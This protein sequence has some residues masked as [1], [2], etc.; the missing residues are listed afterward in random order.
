MRYFCSINRNNHIFPTV[1]WC[2]GLFNAVKEQTFNWVSF[3][4]LIGFREQVMSWPACPL[5][6]RDGSPV[7]LYNMKSFLGWSWWDQQKLLAKGKKGPLRASGRQGSHQIL[8]LIFFGEQMPLMTGYLIGS[9]QKIPDWLIKITL[10]G[11]GEIATGQVWSLGLVL[12][13][14]IYPLF[15]LCIK[16]YLVIM[17]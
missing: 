10:M 6:S 13:F 2:N 17:Y 14:H 11:K 9:D 8:Y 1:C 7:K 12:D 5:A 3:K 15:Y 4:Y 16:S